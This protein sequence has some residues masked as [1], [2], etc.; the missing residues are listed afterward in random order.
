[1]VAAATTITV[2]GEGGKH[3]HPRAMGVV[4]TQSASGAGSS[5]AI[6]GKVELTLYRR[7]GGAW[8]PVSQLETARLTA[9]GSFEK[10]L[11]A[12]WRGTGTSQLDARSSAARQR[13]V[14]PGTYRLYARYPGSRTMKPSACRS[15]RFTLDA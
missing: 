13:P 8:Q 14:Q 10:P 12:F 2:T 6:S 5:G 4:S 11:R 3:R 15:A 7:A 9:R 1:V